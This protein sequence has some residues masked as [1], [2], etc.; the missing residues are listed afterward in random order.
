MYLD[1][2]NDKYNKGILSRKNFRLIYDWIYDVMSAIKKDRQIEYKNIMNTQIF[3]I[4]CTYIHYNNIIRSEYQKLACVAMYLV[5]DKKVELEFF[6]YISNDTY[7]VKELQEFS[8]K[9]EG[10]L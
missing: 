5:Y 6:E 9:V 1:C 8:D 3:N 7:N 2:E 10:I 4:I